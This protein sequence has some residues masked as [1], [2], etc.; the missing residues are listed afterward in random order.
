LQGCHADLAGLFASRPDKVAGDT[1]GVEAAVGMGFR[2]GVMSQQVLSV[3]S[4]DSP[5]QGILLLVTGIA[6][7]SVQDVIIRS[8]SGGYPV[9]E[10]VFVRC[11]VGLLP[12]LVFIRLDGGWRAMRL[13]RPVLVVLRGVAGFTSYTAYYMAIASLPLAKV[14]TLNYTSPLFV[15][16]LSVPILGEV[17]GARRW[18]AVLAGFL[19]VVVIM[20]P[21]AEE[22]DPAV[23]LALLSALSYALMVLI[24]RIVGRSNSGSGL[25]VYSMI[26]FIALSGVIGL[27]I[28]DGRY[29]SESHASAQFLLRA[30][31][32]P[33]ARDF[34]LMVVCGVIAGIGFFCL[35]QAYRVA[36]PSAIAPFEY[37]ALPWAVLWGY[38]FW[39]ELPSGATWAGLALIVGSGLYIVHRE[40]ARGRRTVSSRPLRP[41]I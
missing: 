11:L 27:V 8:L 5:L 14:V 39:A 2:G 38:L 26:V 31:V 10:I 9:H 22:I 17:V 7:F 40:A 36:P 4:Q 35:T 33:G 21:D 30:W 20:R 34:A 1:V 12:L 24:T 18:A 19:G 3:P 32:V 25:S 41:R 28:G 29:D 23:L 15:T 6:V 13:R 16:A 37:S